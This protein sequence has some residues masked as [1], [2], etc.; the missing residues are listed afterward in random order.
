MGYV[1]PTDLDDD[2]V[3]YAGSGGD[4]GLMVPLDQIKESCE[5]AFRSG[6]HYWACDDSKE[7]AMLVI[8]CKSC[9]AKVTDQGYTICKYTPGSRLQGYVIVQGRRVRH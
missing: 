3:P 1:N 4:A 8:Y 5:H 7:E 6:T 9:I 2:R